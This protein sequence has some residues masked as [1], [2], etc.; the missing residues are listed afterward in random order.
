MDGKQQLH[1]QGVHL[2][3][4]E[5]DSGVEFVA[6]FGPGTEGHVDVVGETAI[7]VTGDDQYELDVD[8]DAQVFMKQGI[9]TIKG[10]E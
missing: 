9:L 1:E 3:K 8:E 5:D 2:R 10:D 6:D 4:V 7:I